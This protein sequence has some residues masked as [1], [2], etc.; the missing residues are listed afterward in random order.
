[1]I[2][3]LRVVGVIAA[4]TLGAGM[5][6]LPYVFMKSGWIVGVFYLVALGAVTVFAHVLYLRTLEAVEGRE[7]LLGLA[8]Q[9]LG[10]LGYYIGFFSIIIGLILA[11]VIYLI[12]GVGFVKLFAPSASATF[13]LLAFWLASVLPLLLTE[14]RILWFE[15]LGILFMASII[16]V[17]FASTLPVNGTFDIPSFDPTNIFLPFGAVLFSLA[18]WTAIEPLYRENK[19]AGG[20]GGTGVPAAAIFW[21]TVAVAVLYLLF[22]WGIFGSAASITPD[23]L[24][25]LNNWS[26][27]KLAI[28]G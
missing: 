1:M 27:W 8:R 7:T 3:F 11:L 13:T 22:I 20:V 4:T 17:I 9:K 10:K 2:N 24:S 14:R 26:F 25:G 28:L 16:F 5:F 21:G 6:A 23:T 12:L 15:V 19:E 18:G